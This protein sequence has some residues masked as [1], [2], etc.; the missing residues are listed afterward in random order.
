MDKIEIGKKLKELRLKSGKTLDEVAQ[1]TGVLKQHISNYENGKRTFS[2]EKINK[3]FN[4]YG[5]E[6][7][8]VINKTGNKSK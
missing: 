1:A 6:L 5:F 8:Y 3:I 2:P 7:Q 4:L